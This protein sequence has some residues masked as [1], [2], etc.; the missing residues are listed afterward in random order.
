MTHPVW[1]WVEDAA[2]EGLPMTLKP[3]HVLDLLE[4][5]N[6]VAEDKAVL[7]RENNQLRGRIRELEEAIL[8]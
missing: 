5:H 2:R 4:W 6:A 7:V 3:E 8:A 1:A